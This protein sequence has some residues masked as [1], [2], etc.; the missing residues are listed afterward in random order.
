MN[1]LPSVEVPASPADPVET[2]VKL[3]TRGLDFFYGGNQAL[4]GVSLTMRANRITALIGP[5][6]C[7]KST[8][9]RTLN[10]MNDEI[11]G[12]RVSGEVLL[13][14]QSLYGG[15]VN[16]SKVR[17]RIG[18]VAQRPNP[19]AKSIFDNV[20]YAPRL[21]GTRDRD[22]LAEIVERSLRQAALWDEAKDVLHKSALDLSGGQQQR[23]C[24]ARTLA[25]GPEVLLMDEP[26]S[27]LDPVSTEQIE[28]LLG[29]IKASYTVVI[30]THNLQQ[31]WRVSDHAAFFYQGRLVES[32]ESDVFFSTPKEQKTEDYVR[33]RF[34]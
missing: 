11:D 25:A 18:I 21:F 27:A 20:A 19:F 6:G 13:D 26:C 8:F 2:A 23:L 12:A 17:R 15:G 5:S 3:E 14:G 32:G 22:A 30:V 9:L 33:G 4:H 16:V 7:G 34:G 1:P 28:S 29:E 10:R 24:I 31:A